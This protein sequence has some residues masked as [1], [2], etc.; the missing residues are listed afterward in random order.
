MGRPEEQV[1]RT[2]TGFQIHFQQFRAEEL[3]PWPLDYLIRRNFRADKFSCILAQNLNL[4]EIARKYVLN[5]FTFA[6]EKFRVKFSKNL[7]LF[8]VSIAIYQFFENSKSEGARKYIRAKIS[9]F[10]ADQVRENLSARKIL[11]IR[12]HATTHFFT[13][14][15]NH[16]DH[17]LRP[18][19]FCRTSLHP[20]K[21]FSWILYTIRLQ[22]HSSF[23]IFL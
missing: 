2:G 3:S 19:F 21:C 15:R 23:W 1:F 10:R 9:Y 14:Y 22:L 20:W 5:F 16:L 6:H 7:S 17:F 8:F 4:C 18:L 13:G 11:R 12:Y